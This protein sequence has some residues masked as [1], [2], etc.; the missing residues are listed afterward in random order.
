VREPLICVKTHNTV[1]SVIKHQAVPS[2]A[3]KVFV[4]KTPFFSA[5]KLKKKLLD[6]VTKVAVASCHFVDRSLAEQ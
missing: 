6:Q 2:S 3:K 5:S 4:A 1:N